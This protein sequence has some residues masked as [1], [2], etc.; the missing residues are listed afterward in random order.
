MLRTLDD[1]E[2]KGNL[3]NEANEVLRKMIYTFSIFDEFERVE[4]KLINVNINQV[5]IKT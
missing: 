2:I 1:E 3:I 4:M 5:H